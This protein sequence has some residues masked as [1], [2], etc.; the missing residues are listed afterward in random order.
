MLDHQKK[1]ESL[2][3]DSQR[4]EKQLID[5]F[6]QVNSKVMELSLDL[7]SHHSDFVS[8]SSRQDQALTAIKEKQETLH[9]HGINSTAQLKSH[10]ESVNQSERGQYGKLVGL[11]SG[12][13][14]HNCWQCF[15]CLDLQFVVIYKL[16]LTQVNLSMAIL[17][18]NVQFFALSQERA[19]QD[20]SNDTPQLICEFQVGFPLLWR[21]LGSCVDKPVLWIGQKLLLTALAFTTD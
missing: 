1:M 16:P 12:V 5:L 21:L 18:E 7:G 6:A 3:L 19:C 2:I 14:G 17:S 4:S 9:R 10:F 13:C 20:N 8:Q 15:Q 11:L